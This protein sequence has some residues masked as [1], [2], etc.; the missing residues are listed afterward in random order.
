MGCQKQ[1]GANALDQASGCLVSTKTLCTSQ[2]L[3]FP[4][5]NIN[6]FKL[7]H[8]SPAR[9]GSP[10][11]STE[12]SLDSNEMA[13]MSLPPAH[14]VSPKGDDEVVSQ[15]TVP[16]RGEVPE[17]IRVAPKDDSSAAGH[18]GKKPPWG[19]V[20]GAKFHSAL[21][22]IPFRKSIRLRGSANGTPPKEGVCLFH[23]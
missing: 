16:G 23:R 21:S 22:R 12:G 4:V 15:R 7:C 9:D 18:M 11:S 1:S 20:V 10:R 5:Y 8:Y 17:I 13:S 6:M 3:A 14:S 2:Y 19:L